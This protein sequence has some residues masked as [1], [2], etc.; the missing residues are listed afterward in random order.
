MNVVIY[1]AGSIGNHLAYGCRNKGWDVLICDIDAEA[2]ER[3]KQDIYPARY[4]KWDDQ[5]RLATSE[6]LP[7]ETFDLAIIGTPPDSHLEIA[8]SLLH[9]RPPKIL[10]IEKPVCTPSLE[11]AQEVSDMAKAAGTFACVGYNH[12]LTANTVFAE[13][14]L[15][16]SV[17]GKPLTISARFREH[18]GGIFRAH[19]WLNGPQDTYLG[20][21]QRGGG[22]CGE[23]SHAINIWQ[24]FAHIC[25][26]GRIREVS[27]KLDIVQEE[28][29]ANYDRICLI[30]VITEHGF[31]GDIAQD[32]V[33]EPAQKTVRIQG[34][35]GFLEWYCNFASG[36]DAVL[37]SDG[38]NP[39]QKDILE[40]TRPDD[41]KG[42]IDH[43]E[44]ILQNAGSEGVMEGY[45]HSPI[46]L[47]RGLD[48]MLV[49]AAA[50]LSHQE[51]RTVKINYE[52]GYRSEALELC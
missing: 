9:N 6:K 47:E 44:Q 25:G 48:T 31:V 52:A 27:A 1:G 18:W 46:A 12:T 7:D 42:E 13:R 41:F 3:T 30:H 29:G 37:W 19:P 28:S 50:H 36:Q 10:L 32:V 8:R 33:T 26:M 2:L 38:K 20:F 34:D 23:H 4:G 24:H 11:G 16:E 49:V 39:L 43:I 45:I 35:Q 15:A 5:I 17:I 14:Q 40:K 22:A 51:K 21:W